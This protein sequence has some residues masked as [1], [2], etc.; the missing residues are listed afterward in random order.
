MRGVSLG[1]VRARAYS[2]LSCEG[3]RRKGGTHLADDPPS[4]S[5]REVVIHV[6]K[7]Q[8]IALLSQNHENRIEELQ[9]LVVVVKPNE[10]PQTKIACDGIGMVAPHLELVRVTHAHDLPHEAVTAPSVVNHLQ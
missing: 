1:K 3:R 4:P 5:D 6:E 10:K 8:L 7:A 2:C 9:V